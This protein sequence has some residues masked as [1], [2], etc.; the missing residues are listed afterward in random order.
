MTEVNFAFPPF[1]SDK[2]CLVVFVF[3]V[4]VYIHVFSP[5]FLKEWLATIRHTISIPLKRDK[6]HSMLS[7]RHRVQP[8][9]S[10]VGFDPCHIML[11]LFPFQ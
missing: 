10:A 6:L 2:K 7:S 9:I 11:V 1:R 8:P 4:C 3:A 5:F